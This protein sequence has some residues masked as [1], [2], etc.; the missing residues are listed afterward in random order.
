M[1]NKKEFI[2][3]MF[4]RDILISGESPLEKKSRFFC[5]ILAGTRRQPAGFEYR[6][7]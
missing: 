3:N 2:E 1:E 4:Q 6:L 5:I 7:S